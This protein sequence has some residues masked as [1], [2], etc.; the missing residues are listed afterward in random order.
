M[1]VMV[2]DE[3]GQPVFEYDDAAVGSSSYPSDLSVRA[4]VINA[5]TAALRFL[6]IKKRGNL[7]SEI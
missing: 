7:D 2:T 5:L 6:L 4:K 3:Q 1:R